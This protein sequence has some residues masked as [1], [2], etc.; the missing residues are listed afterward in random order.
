[1]LYKLKKYFSSTLQFSN[2]NWKVDDF[3]KPFQDTGFEP[4]ELFSGQRDD[5]QCIL[6]YAESTVLYAVA[7]LS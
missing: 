3:K 4:M 5:A 7:I 2:I 1:M 6:K